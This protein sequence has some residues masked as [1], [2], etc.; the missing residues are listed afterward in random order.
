MKY[1]QPCSRWLPEAEPVDP[2]FHGLLPL[3]L[4]GARPRLI[5]EGKRVKDIW[6]VEPGPRQ[7]GTARVSTATRRLLPSPRRLLGWGVAAVGT[8]CVAFVTLYWVSHALSTGWTSTDIHNYILGG[9]RLNAGHPFYGYGPGDERVLLSDPGTD[10]PIYSPPLIGVVFRLFVLLPAHGLYVW[11]GLMNL[12]EIAAIV[13]LVRRATLV[14]G[15][16]LIPLS[17]CIGC[18]MQYGNVDCLLVAGLLL[19]WWWITRGHDGWA[20]VAIAVLA[21]IKLTP[22][23]LVWWLVV[24]GRRRAAA[25]AIG[26]GIGLVIVAMAGTEAPIFAKFY[27]V[28]TAN[29]AGAYGLLTPAAWARAVGVPAEI[30]AV[31]PRIVLIG[32]AALM[33]AV[34]KRPALA[35]SIGALLMWLGSPVA[36]L[37]TPALA[38]LALAPLA[39]NLPSRSRAP[40]SEAGNAVDLIAADG[41]EAPAPGSRKAGAVS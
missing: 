26:C 17:I 36:D 24:T 13:V 6:N 30:A 23:I 29:F 41:P 3:L 39:W 38:L 28:T 1:A 5:D 19:A 34:R 11:W 16:V 18:A 10:Y 27:E 31:M 8:C 37:Q 7:N 25:I 32:G 35:W 15:L 20:A 22:V 14:T 2:G 9:L 12:L 40:K 33:W 4:D 21:S